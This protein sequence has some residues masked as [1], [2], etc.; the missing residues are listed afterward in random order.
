MRQ[1]RKSTERPE[2]WALH[3]ATTSGAG[4]HKLA[5]EPLRAQYRLRTLGRL[6]ALQRFPPGSASGEQMHRKP[7]RPSSST[8]GPQTENICWSYLAPFPWKLPNSIFLQI[9]QISPISP[10]TS[11]L[12]RLLSQDYVNSPKTGLLSSTVHRTLNQ[13]S[14]NTNLHAKFLARGFLT[15]RTEHTPLPQPRGPRQPPCSPGRNA[16]RQIIYLFTPKTRRPQL[17]VPLPWT[18]PHYTS[19]VFSLLWEPDYPGVTPPYL[20]PLNFHVTLY[21]RLLPRWHW[22]PTAL[23]YH[24]PFSGCSSLL[25]ITFLINLTLSIPEA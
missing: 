3:R 22:E 11:P 18:F 17:P 7:A 21:N 5:P 2:E 15:V 6:R 12:W 9:A 20:L 16:M 23:C 1:S 13:L 10:L 14:Y 4:K 8:A 25:I 19:S 24:L